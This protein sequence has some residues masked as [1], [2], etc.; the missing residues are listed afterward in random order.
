MEF[1]QILD[2]LNHHPYSSDKP[3][4]RNCNCSSSNETDSYYRQMEQD[5]TVCTT[6]TNVGVK[7]ENGSSNL[8]M[9]FCGCMVSMIK[10][11]IC[12]R[13]LPSKYIASHMK[14]THLVKA[15]LIYRF[16]L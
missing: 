9:D 15:K 13:N 11:N 5:T 2:E 8:Q 16:F 12:G 14:K 4:S 7:R 3:V 10:C 6:P 1:K